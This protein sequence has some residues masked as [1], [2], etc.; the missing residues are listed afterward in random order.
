LK[1]WIVILLKKT[2]TILSTGRELAKKTNQFVHYAF[3]L[4]I[5]KSFETVPLVEFTIEIFAF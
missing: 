3:N 2:P 1:L 5:P 4:N